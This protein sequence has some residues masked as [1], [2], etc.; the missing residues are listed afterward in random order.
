MFT[1]ARISI[2]YRAGVHL[3]A[4]QL[5]VKQS[6]T[7]HFVVRPFPMALAQQN[8]AGRNRCRQKNV[9][10]ASFAHNDLLEHLDGPAVLRLLGLYKFDS[11]IGLLIH[12]IVGLDR[13]SDGFLDAVAYPA[14]CSK[15]EL[16]VRE[17]LPS[18]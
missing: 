8:P 13:Q 9:R 5:R 7:V 16:V 18:H 14:P 1:N 11:H 17:E 12:L 3:S 6:Y 4:R 2:A 10:D 15:I